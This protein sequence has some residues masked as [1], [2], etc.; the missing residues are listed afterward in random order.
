MS[1]LKQC[2]YMAKFSKIANA[3]IIIPMRLIACLYAV[4]F[5]VF[6]VRAGRRSTRNSMVEETIGKVPFSWMQIIG[7]VS[8]KFRGMLWMFLCKCLPYL[9]RAARIPR[10][11]NAMMGEKII[12]RYILR[13]CRSS[14]DIVLSCPGFP[15]LATVLWGVP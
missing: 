14:G 1:T 9:M 7:E 3:I 4:G 10:S 5:A 11:C 12:E 15:V 13:S 8:S 6:P 2:L